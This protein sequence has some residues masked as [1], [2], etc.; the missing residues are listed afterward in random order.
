M[1]AIQNPF[2]FILDNFFYISTFQHLHLFLPCIIISSVSWSLSKN[3]FLNHFMN[4][5]FLSNSKAVF[6][7]VDLHQNDLE[8]DENSYLKKILNRNFFT[9]QNKIFSYMD[10]S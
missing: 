6:L 3:D 9:I 7:N 5:F 4:H 10:S 8:Y 1:L 2:E